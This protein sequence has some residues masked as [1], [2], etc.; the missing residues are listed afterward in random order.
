V[1]IQKNNE[2]NQRISE[3]LRIDLLVRNLKRVVS[4]L[5]ENKFL[6]LKLN[7]EFSSEKDTFEILT[8]EIYQEKYF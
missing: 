5:V 2:E 4:S 3:L 6:T 8:Q 1:L 7:S